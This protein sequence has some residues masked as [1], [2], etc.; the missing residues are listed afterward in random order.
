MSR[1]FIFL[2]LLAGL[3]AGCERRH[4]ADP[5][6]VV[7][8]ALQGVLVYP[9][10]Q[11]VSIAAGEDAGQATL[12]SQDSVRVVAKWFRQALAANGWKL[13]S[14]RTAQ[15]GTVSLYAET[16]DK[17]P[18]WITLKPNVGAPGTTYTLIGAIVT[19][20]GAAPPGAPRR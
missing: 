5:R 13:Q 19:D 17:R 4:D 18:L 15:D 16:G 8:R 9:Y 7:S 10:S 11:E 6:P 14:D 3:A 20:S 1:S 2:T 12:V